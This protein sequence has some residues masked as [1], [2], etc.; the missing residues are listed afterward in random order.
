MT[1][2]GSFLGMP[3]RGRGVEQGLAV[4]QCTRRT[5]QG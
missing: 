5:G 1:A 4:L 3:A 2:R